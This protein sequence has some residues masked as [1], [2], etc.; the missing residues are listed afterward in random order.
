MGLWSPPRFQ[1]STSL[2]CH[3]SVVSGGNGVHHSHYLASWAPEQHSET[4]CGWLSRCLF[5]KWGNRLRMYLTKISFC[6]FHIPGSLQ[7]KNSS[8]TFWF[9]QVFWQSFSRWL[10]MAIWWSRQGR[11]SSLLHDCENRS[12]MGRDLPRVA[13]LKVLWAQTFQVH[14]QGP[15]SCWLWNSSKDISR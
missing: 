9:P 10:L 15:F 6:K 7:K 3:F 8:N 13:Q 1:K 4:C 2:Y 14:V 5:Y 12:G 11:C